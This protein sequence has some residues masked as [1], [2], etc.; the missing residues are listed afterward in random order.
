MEYDRNKRRQALEPARGS[1]TKDLTHQKPQIEPAH[2]HHE[3]LEDVLSS[4]QVEPTH[5]AGFMHMG[6]RALD[7][8]PPPPESKNHFYHGLMGIRT[9]LTEP[10][11]NTSPT[12]LPPRRSR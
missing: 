2:V 10:R 7:Q 6:K 11:A 9:C 1:Q 4:L 3:T 5:P 8:L 12:G